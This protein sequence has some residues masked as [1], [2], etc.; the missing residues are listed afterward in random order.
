MN[1]DPRSARTT[2]RKTVLAIAAALL[3]SSLPAFCQ[4]APCRS[5]TG[6]VKVAYPD[7]AR[8]M[9]IYGIVRLQLQLSPTGSVRESKILGGNPVLAGAAQQ[10]VK[11][12]HFEGAESCIITFE[13]KE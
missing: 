2:P 10:S 1:R 4:E 3:L 12:A 5:K 13:F 7:L 6:E 9:K 11:N 8:R